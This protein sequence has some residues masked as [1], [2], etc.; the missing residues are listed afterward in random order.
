MFGYKRVKRI[1]IRK[2][3]I[4]GRFVCFQ[5]SFGFLISTIPQGISLLK[6]IISQR[7]RFKD[8]WSRHDKARGV[9]LED[10]R[11]AFTQSTRKGVAFIEG[12]KLS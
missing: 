12:E 6:E 4:K 10:V 9:I 7:E 2:I 11:G 5:F 1:C 8:A 3:G